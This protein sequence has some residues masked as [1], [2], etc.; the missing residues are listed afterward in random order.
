MIG[1]ICIPLYS[2]PLYY[3]WKRKTQELEEQHYHLIVS[4]R[5]KNVKDPTETSNDE[6]ELTAADEEKTAS[7]VNID[8]YYNDGDED[9]EKFTFEEYHKIYESKAIHRVYVGGIIFTSASCL[10]SDF[11]YLPRSV[12]P[13]SFSL[14]FLAICFTNFVLDGSSVRKRWILRR[15]RRN[16]AYLYICC[17]TLLIALNA[18]T[19]LRDIMLESG[20]SDEEQGTY[21]RIGTSEIIDADSEDGANDWREIIASISI[22][23]FSILLVLLWET[24]AFKAAT[25]ETAG[26]IMFPLYFVIDITQTY[27]FLI[28]PFMSFKFWTILLCQE[29]MGAFRNCGGY[30]I[31]LWYLQHIFGMKRP[32]P[33]SDL[34]TLEELITIAAVDTVAEALAAFSYFAFLIGAKIVGTDNIAC[35]FEPRNDE[36]SENVANLGEMAVTLGIVV[37]SRVVWFLIE[38]IMFRSCVEKAARSKSSI[39]VHEKSLRRRRASIKK[40]LS[41][42]VSNT[43][44]GNLTSLLNENCTNETALSDAKAYILDVLQERSEFWVSCNTSKLCNVTVH[45]YEGKEKLASCPWKKD[46]LTFMASV[47]LK[48]CSID[49]VLKSDLDFVGEAKENER[50]SREILDA[51]DLTTLER[52]RVLYQYNCTPFGMANTDAVIADKVEFLGPEEALLIGAPATWEGKEKNNDAY[53][54]RGFVYGMHYTD[55]SPI[56]VK[57]GEEEQGRALRK[58]K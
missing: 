31:S 40:S 8:D 25:T 34:H 38:R 13:G 50:I 4:A 53:R 15:P 17:T 5:R 33:L 21:N 46:S 36:C 55:C 9:L 30:E 20:V 56:G 3:A 29:I 11:G 49:D 28:V 14:V 27:L 24:M 26:P 7:S 1:N 12:I 45:Q 44:A 2:L 19:L 43:K 32:F 42:L 22:T 48:N 39:L 41:K 18:L 23:M 47:I 16:T 57:R 58:P 51:G 37:L 6:D 52:E 54:N 35:L 10:G